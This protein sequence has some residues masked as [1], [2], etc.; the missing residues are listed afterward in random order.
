MFTFLSRVWQ[1][2][3]QEQSCYVLPTSVMFK[4]LSSERQQEL[5]ERR[6]QEIPNVSVPNY[7]NVIVIIRERKEFEGGGGRGETKVKQT[8]DKTLLLIAVDCCPIK[9]WAASESAGPENETATYGV[10]E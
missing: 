2:G 1:K 10:Q 8:S 3:L 9:Y 5:Q 6:N 4:F 7:C